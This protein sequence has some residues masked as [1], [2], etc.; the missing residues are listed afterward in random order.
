MTK[1][2][3]LKS[4]LTRVDD[5]TNNIAADIRNLAAKIGT[6]LTDA[7]V[8][9]LQTALEAAAVKLEATAAVTPDEPPA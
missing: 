7:E 1:L 3:D 8:T 2:D 4:I 5:A 6:G 9:E